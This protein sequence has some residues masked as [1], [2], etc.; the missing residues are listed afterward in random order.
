MIT[1][2]WKI[3][4]WTNLEFTLDKRLIKSKLF[5]L[6][7][8]ENK[9][10]LN[11]NIKSKLKEVLKAQIWQLML[12]VSLMLN[13]NTIEA[14]SNLKMMK[15]FLQWAS[16]GFKNQNLSPETHE[17]FKLSNHRISTKWCHK[18]VDSKLWSLKD[19]I[20]SPSQKTFTALNQQHLMKSTKHM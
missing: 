3:I 18:L 15:F 9:L 2:L 12:W 1:K 17:C 20:N 7:Q 10:V 14:Q 11:K 13:R 5:I 4:W 16:I 8:M 19:K 6:C